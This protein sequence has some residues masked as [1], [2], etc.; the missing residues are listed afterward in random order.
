LEQ[1]EGAATKPSPLFLWEMGEAYAYRRLAYRRMAT[2]LSVE[3]NDRLSTIP[4]AM[5]EA[6]MG[7]E[8]METRHLVQA[9][10]PPVSEAAARAVAALRANGENIPEDLTP[11]PVEELRVHQHE[12]EL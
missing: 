12:D 5:L 2:I 11:Q 8:P 9:R 1:V 7:T 3:R 10:T 6:V 4:H